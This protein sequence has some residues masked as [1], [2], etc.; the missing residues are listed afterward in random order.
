MSYA[1]GSSTVRAIQPALINYFARRTPSMLVAQELTQDTWTALGE[2]RGEGTLRAFLFRVAFT[3]LA[4]WYRQERRQGLHLVHVEDSY[5][6][7]LVIHSWGSR[8]QASLDIRVMLQAIDDLPEPLRR[9][10]LMILHG[11]STAD[12]ALRE[13]VSRRTVRSRL[14]R[15]R[16]WLRQRLL[17]E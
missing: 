10:V 12:I 5:L 3:V 1:V 14:S 4:D 7:M 16:T 11:H 9:T 13:G 2:Y 15:A 8:A 6:P 17:N